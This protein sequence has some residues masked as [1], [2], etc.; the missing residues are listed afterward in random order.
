MTA[1]S[2]TPHI[3]RWPAL[4][5][6]EHHVLVYRRTWRG[7]LFTSFLN[8]VLFLAAMG[9]GLGSLVDANNPTGVGGTAYLTFLAPGLLAATAMQTAAFESTYPIMAGLR[10]MKTYDA[11]VTTP[12]TSRGVVLGQVLWVTTRIFLVTSVFSL[13]M[14]AF[15]A[16]SVP[17][18]LIALPFAVATGLAFAAPLQAF[19]ATQRNDTRFTAIFRFGIT[20]LFIFSGTFFPISQLPDLIEPMAWLT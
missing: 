4:R 2:V 16:V 8:P 5:V 10:W 1:R 18:A 7:S 13:V 14:I 9:L 17:G 15:G 20:P 11:M 19:A 12:I 6:Y 3:T